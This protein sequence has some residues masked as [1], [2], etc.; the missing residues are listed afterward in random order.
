MNIFLKV[1]LMVKLVVITLLSL[2]HLACASQSNPQFEFLEQSIL[3][4]PFSAVVSHTDVVKVASNSNDVDEYL[5]HADVIE[6]I[7]GKPQR[8]IS[9][10]MYVEHGED[11]ILNK[12]PAIISLCKDKNDYYWP[13]VGAEFSASE[14]LINVARQAAKVKRKHKDVNVGNLCS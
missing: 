10:R 1:I 2:S 6:L 7:S 12:S 13:G 4:T 3:G 14:A 8:Q 11:V 5:L 9:Y